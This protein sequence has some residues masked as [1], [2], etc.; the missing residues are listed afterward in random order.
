MLYELSLESCLLQDGSADDM[1][2]TVS[3][4]VTT[5]KVLVIRSHCSCEIN[6]VIHHL[7][8]LFQSLRLHMGTNSSQ[9]IVWPTR[10]IV[11]VCLGLLADEI[12]WYPNMII[13][14]C[15]YANVN[16]AYRIMMLPSACFTVGMMVFLGLY[17]HN[18]LTS[19]LDET[20]QVCGSNSAH[21]IRV[22]CVKSANFKHASFILAAEMIPAPFHGLLFSVELLWLLNFSLM[23]SLS[24]VWEQI[25]QILYGW[26]ILGWF[27]C[28]SVNF[29][30]AYYQTSCTDGD[31]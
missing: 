14:G 28:V 25:V 31:D 26:P 29:P 6:N 21:R 10:A 13:W 30:P 7:G 9:E 5:T 1:R 8:S 3:R 19:K 16:E 18:P 24:S 12:K 15:F 23:L 2:P 11:A 20:I 4:Y 22:H 27:R 17:T